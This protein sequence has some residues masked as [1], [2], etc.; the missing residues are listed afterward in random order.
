MRR[1]CALIVAL[2]LLG[3]CGSDESEPSLSES[4][5]DTTWVSESDKIKEYRDDGT[6]GVSTSEFDDVSEAN[7]EWGTW[8]LDGNMLTVSPDTES[9]FCAEVTATY[10]VELVDDG[11]RLDVSVQDDPCEPRREDFSLGLTRR[12]DADP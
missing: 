11:N 12:A 5:T 6:Y 9:P 4:L 1:T 7:R 2:L 8:S 10:L 3:G